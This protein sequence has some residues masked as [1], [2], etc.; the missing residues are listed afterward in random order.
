MQ[1]NQTSAT[2]SIKLLTIF[3]VIISGGLFVRLYGLSD[4]AFNSDE[5]WHLAIANQKSIWEVLDYNFREEIH[6]PLSVI[7]YHFMLQLSENEMWLRMSSIIPSIALIPSAYLFGRLYI[8]KFA[9]FTAAIIF[10][11]GSAPLAVSSVIRAYSLFMLTLTWTAIFARKYYLQ[12]TVKNLTGYFI[13]SLLS[14]ELHHSGA[15]FILASGLLLMK[16]SL[17]QKNKQG[18][19]DFIIIALG[20]LL[21]ALVLIGYGY[22]ISRHYG[23]KDGNLFSTQINR[24]RTVF[25]YFA[26]FFDFFFY[27]LFDQKIHNDFS[28]L[29]FLFSLSSFIA[30]PIALIKHRRWDLLHI[31]FTPLIAI[32][33]ADYFGHYPFSASIRRELFLFPSILILYGYFAQSLASSIRSWSEAWEI[34]NFQINPKLNLIVLA[35]VVAL[36]AIYVAKNNFFRNARPNCAEFSVTK[37]EMTLIDEKLATKNSPQ[38]IFVTTRSNVWNLQFRSGQNVHITEITKNLAKFEN[39]K[40][41]LYFTAFPERELATTASML[42]YKLFFADLFAYLK[43]RGEFNR[44]KSITLFSHD[45]SNDYLSMI[46]LPQFIITPPKIN[47]PND[48]IHRDHWQEGYDFGFTIHRSKQVTDRFRMQNSAASCGQNVLILSFTPQ[49]ILEEILSKNFVKVRE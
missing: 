15:F 42:E 19:R 2:N 27:F 30:A 41:S 32:S 22:V 20:H 10:A 6:P 44:I 35:A 39:G 46:F 26:I 36:L 13:C 38:N 33:L 34:K 16:C 12:P 49:F 47:K 40:L 37:E 28:D 8:G 9:G 3:L 31:T 21:L 7:I 1:K 18:K 11:F 14:L 23:L 4:Y 45:L 48:Q 43:A 24:S 5:S 25:S 29:L 17:N